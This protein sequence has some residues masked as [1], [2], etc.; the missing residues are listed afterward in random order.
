MSGPKTQK[1]AESLLA[2]FGFEEEARAYVLARAPC[3]L[4]VLRRE[5]KD[6]E[7]RGLSFS[8][9]GSATYDEKTDQLLL[10]PD[11]VLI[12][13]ENWLFVFYLRAGE[14]RVERFSKIIRAGGLRSIDHTK[15]GQYPLPD[16]MI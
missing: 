8:W 4:W 10:W 9:P 13:E 12:G 2:Y 14:Q 1:R 15:A 5:R 3:V 11:P 7:R 16:L 6:R